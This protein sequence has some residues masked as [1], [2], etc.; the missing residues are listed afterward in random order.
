MDGEA[1][2]TCRQRVVS[3]SAAV[4]LLTATLAVMAQEGVPPEA[5][6]V[7][8]A[9]V[10][11]APALAPQVDEPAVASEARPKEPEASAQAEPPADEVDNPQDQVE[12]IMITADRREKSIQRYAGSATALTQ[13]DL[14]KL[15]VDS[16]KTL[17]NAAP[18]VQ[19][20]VQEGNVEVNIRGVGSDNNTE[21]GDP[22]AAT[23]I[24]GVYIPRPRGVGSMFY[25][26]ERVE[27]NRGPQGTL[28]GRNATAGSLNIITA[29][30]NLRKFGADA[31]M[32]LGSYNQRL[33]KL[34][35]NIPVW[36]DKLAMRFATFSDNHDPFY[37]NGGPVTFLKPTEGADVASYRLS[38]KALPHERVMVELSYD[39][40]QEQ[41]S[42]YG[43][44]N[45]A[46][47]LKAGLRPDDIPDWRKV[48][49]RGPQANQDMDHS[50]FRATMNVDLG[51]VQVEYL[52]SYRDLIYRQNTGGNAGVYFNGMPDPVLDD[53]S[54][55]IWRTTSRSQ[56]HELRLYAPK[57]S[58]LKWTVGG[59][60]F[61]EQQTSFLG[62]VSDNQNWY[63][64]G[65]FNM[66]HVYDDSVA[67]FLDM[68]FDITKIFRATGG[69]RVTQE[70]KSRSGIASGYSFPNMV[71]WNKMRFGTEGFAWAGMD[72]TSY[73]TT[74]D[75]REFFRAGIKRWGTRDTMQAQFDN[76]DTSLDKASITPQEG[77]YKNKFL[78]W[79]L[80]LDCDLTPNSLVYV[81]VATGHKSG[82]FNDNAKANVV[83]PT[84]KPESL[85]AFE[86][87]SKNEFLN[88]KLRVNA[89]VFDYEYQDQVF[90]NVVTLTDSTDPNAVGFA[91]AVRDNVASSRILGLEV[92]GT[93]RLPL[94]FVASV[95]ALVLDAKFGDSEVRESRISWDTKAEDMVSLDGK[96][97]PKSSRLTV[98]YSLGQTFQTKLGWFD[99]LVSA[100]TRTKYYLTI[101]NGEGKDTHGVADP[102]LTDVN[103]AYTRIDANVGYTHPGDKVRIDAFVTNLSDLTFMTSLI[104]TPGLNLRF[105]NPPRQ[106]GL[107]AQVTW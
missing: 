30:P 94:G 56:I 80:G 52:G 61:G 66:P 44:S 51:P 38:A 14:Q 107:R 96:W 67:G 89:A 104:N 32:Q 43:G 34:M 60:Y 65:E 79:R 98:N 45:F 35:L 41:G 26:L 15:G 69:I 28:R 64:G 99:W 4:L 21:L 5:R 82:G 20:G 23:H 87:G 2:R 77:S 102:N 97:L 73:D 50:G 13:K 40:T 84:Y 17:S 95:S 24:D 78:D 92:E 18:A 58:R 103:P 72:R 100:Q 9:E 36:E 12:T 46:A 3:L 47:A 75:P 27:I 10:S 85:Y 106:F 16:V 76:P 83:A 74:I 90:Q 11:P 81:S 57:D 29:K 105:F 54:T 53:Y 55:S 1:K 59:F 62:N 70:S 68:I 31:L 39:Y 101:F 8:A 49:Y 88:K 22:A 71:S 37:K 25:D 63:V 7:Q 42:G 6:E 19:V 33:T 86:L 93:Y 91:A 48:I